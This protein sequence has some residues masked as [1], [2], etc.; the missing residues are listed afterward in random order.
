M[1]R[2]VAAVFDVS[3]YV[4]QCAVAAVFGAY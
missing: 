4:V 1:Q 2:A 3:L